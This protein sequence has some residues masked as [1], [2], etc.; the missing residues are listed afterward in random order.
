MTLI[1]ALRLAIAHYHKGAFADAEAVCRAILRSVPM[2]PETL[3]LLGVV[4]HAAGDSVAGGRALHAAIAVQPDMIDAW[5]NLGV[6]RQNTSQIVAAVAALER[7]LLLAPMRPEGHY[8]LAGAKTARGDRAGAVESYFRALA[9]R[10][11]DAG[12]ANAAGSALREMGHVARAAAAHRRALSVDPS[13]ADAYRDLGHALRE[14][15][16]LRAAATAYARVALTSPSR[17]DAVH[18]EMFTRQA[19]CDWSS[20]DALR[21]RIHEI[22]AEDKQYILPLAG[23][24]MDTAAA[25][26]LRAARRFYRANV[27]PRPQPE[28]PP[29]RRRAAAD[30]RLTV[31]Y[32]SAD[33]H[34]H[35]T[36]YLAAEMFELHDR[37][38]FRVLAYSYG[39][40]DGSPMRRRLTAAFEEFR[41]VRHMGLDEVTALAQAD[42]VD[43]FVDL[44]GYTKQSRLDMLSRRLA[45]V[46][47]S[48]LGYPGTLGS[49]CMDYIIGDRFVTPMEHEPFY[50]EKIVQLPDSYQI[51]DRRRPLDGRVPTR[52]ECGLPEDAAVFCA[53]NTTYKIN[54]MMFDVW[55]RLLH[56]QP[57]AVL[58]LFEANAAAKDN[59]LREAAARGVGP[60]RLVFAPKRPLADHLARH[61]LADA[62]LD[63]FPY[64]GHTTTSDALW[65]GLPVVT[66]LGDTFASRVAAGLLNAAGL[67]ET[68]AADLPEY[69]AKALRLVRD[70]DLLR[71][72]RRRL[73]ETRMQVPLFD[74]LRF[75]RHMERAFETMWAIHE[76]G[77][78]P[79][80]FAVPPLEGAPPEGTPPERTPPAGAFA[81]ASVG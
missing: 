2:Q 51:N 26:Q 44:K 30:G 81:T 73:E 11:D 49:D 42:G 7:A 43:V 21:A 41:L 14:A 4:L 62:A 24:S 74:S 47:A 39:V 5:S 37:S 18:Y 72:Y 45:P 12:S 40:D 69:E 52:A 67:P 53:F 76:S 10:P 46:Q 58:W 13:F 80:S 48:Y 23:L 25:E 22:I 17:A 34:E 16:D 71:S 6:V 28:P 57:G 32:G 15:G 54:P 68:V 35:A 3:Q 19:Y 59:L 8:N 36:A 38:R 1:E 63:S 27:Q 31:A 64:T 50:S 55:M 20:Y 33:Y 66:L 61:R 65:A 29:R 77:A 78:P 79:R 9:L 60:E 75:T 70:P 56:A